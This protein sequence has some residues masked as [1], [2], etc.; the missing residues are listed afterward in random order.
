MIYPS[1][2]YMNQ[3]IPFKTNYSVYD[4][5]KLTSLIS[6]DVINAIQTPCCAEDI[7]FRQNMFKFLESEITYNHFNI[8][9]ENMER[10]Y[11]LNTSY[12]NARTENEKYIIFASLMDAFMI[13]MGNVTSQISNDNCECEIY[14]R[15]KDYFIGEINKNHY[16]K[17]ISDLK[18]LESS[19]ALIR[20]N[21]FKIHGETIK[22]AKGKPVTYIDRIIECAAN[23]GLSELNIRLPVN[24]QLSADIIDTIALLYPEE[25]KLFKEF[26]DANHNYYINDI[27]RY[28]TE[29]AFFLDFI[30]I[31]KEIK[32]NGIPM[33]YPI[34]SESRKINV[35]DAYD[36]TL[37][38]KNERSIIPNDIDFTDNEPFFY[39][40][41][42]NGGGKTTYLRTVGITVLMFLNGCPVACRKAEIY[43]LYKMFTHFPRDERFENT[44]RFDEEQMRVNDILANVDPNSLVLLNETY[45]TATE[46]DAVLLTGKL[47]DTLYQSGAYGIYVTH[48]HGISESEIPY[49]NVVVDRNDENRRTYKVAKRRNEYGSY[50]IDVLK[51]YALTREM[52]SERF[53]GV[54]Q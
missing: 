25:M 33:C 14:T 10:L 45:S 8:L 15:F 29:I 3:P 16:K 35:S 40:T 18:G 49:L 50:A 54:K 23:L 52:L 47:A 24:K 6:D 30:K 9:S 26:Y 5:L 43:P 1:L 31:F 39:L 13:F 48:Q 11:Q 2:L 20:T 19:I 7:I 17:V 32:A 51:K 38:T 34:I 4:D 42:A 46:D 27:L 36:I 12:T 37:L 28:K 41:G 22:I 53:N 44:G 21:I